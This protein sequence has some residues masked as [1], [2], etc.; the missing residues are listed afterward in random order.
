MDEAKG[1]GRTTAEA[2]RAAFAEALREKASRRRSEDGDSGS[3]GAHE[4]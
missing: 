4:V 1:R 3:D 2:A